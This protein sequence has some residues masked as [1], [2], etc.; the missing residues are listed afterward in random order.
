M[1]VLLKLDQFRISPEVVRKAAEA[2]VAGQVLL[3]P[4]DTIYGLGCDALNPAAV[5]KVFSIKRRDASNPT[6]ILASDRGMVKKLV[7]DISPLAARLMGTFWPG[8]LTMLFRAKGDLPDVIRSKE[9]KIAIRIPA[10]QFCLR[11]VEAAGVPIVSTSAN[12]SGQPAMTEMRQL[13]KTFLP[14]VDIFINAGSLPLSAPSTII[15]VTGENAVIV[16]EGAIPF[17][18]IEP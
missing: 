10:N 3:Y 18:E 1:G 8:P 12:I 14:E 2:V 11:V 13:R 5:E 9:G 7:A 6:L 16:R 17:N 15:D 4:T